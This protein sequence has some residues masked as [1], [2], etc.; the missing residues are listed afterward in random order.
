[1]QEIS[2]AAFLALNIEC[3][4]KGPI[5]RKLNVECSFSPTSITL[6]RAC[7]P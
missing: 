4:R 6:M 2:L 1:M 7:S 5:L 3:G